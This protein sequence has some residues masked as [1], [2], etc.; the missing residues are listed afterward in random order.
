MVGAAACG[1][2]VGDWSTAALDCAAAL[3]GDCAAVA[4]LVG[5]CVA[6]DA[7]VGDFIAACLAGDSAAAALVGDCVAAA[8][9]WRSRMMV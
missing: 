6:V 3:V 4:G 1:G 9:G 2:L 5:C 8:L 7:L